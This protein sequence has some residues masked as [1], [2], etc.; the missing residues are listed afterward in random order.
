MLPHHTFDSVVTFEDTKERKPSPAPFKKML[1]KLTIQPEEAL[2]VGDWAERDIDGA[3]KIGMKTAF[4]RYGDTF[5]T[6]EH[7]ADYELSDISQLI[8]I[9]TKENIL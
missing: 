3:K 6:K 5:D 2:M 1:E 8:D 7:N 9:V 4:A